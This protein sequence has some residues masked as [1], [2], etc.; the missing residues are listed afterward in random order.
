MIPAGDFLVH[1]AQW[2]GRPLSDLVGLVRGQGPMSLGA[3]AELSR[4]AEALRADPVGAEAL[5]S[6]DPPEDVLAA[7]ATRPGPVGAAT[8]DFVDLVGHWSVGSG[9]DVGEPCLR[10]MPSLLVGNVRAA[11]AGTTFAA[12]AAAEATAAVRADVP[13]AGRRVFDELLAEARATHRVRDERATYCDVWAY[14]LARRALLAAGAHLAT[15]GAVEQPEHVVE[16]GHAEL[17]AL[18]SGARGPPAG[19]LA[20]R[21]RYRREASE[22][23]VPVVLGGPPRTPVPVEWLPAGAARTERAFRAYVGAMS[24]EAPDRDDGAGVDGLAASP[25]THEG[26]ARVVRSATELGR[27]EPGDVLVTASTTP[28]FNAV[29]PL[30]GAIV[31]DRGGL[32][33][34]AAIVAREYGVP[35]VVGTREATSVIPDGAVIR[36]DGDTGEVQFTR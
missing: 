24:A 12:P 13:P 19:E 21:A 11:A 14:G 29:L 6:H 16:A 17:H 20:G 8:A 35:A 7:L 31:T 27:I 36:V 22:D 23:R 15:T 26:R 3:A 1:A 4:L 28:A 9:S 5:A 18:L 34:H 10:E 32:L 30:V 25:G 2:T 33:S